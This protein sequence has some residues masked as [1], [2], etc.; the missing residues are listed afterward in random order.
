MAERSNQFVLNRIR[1]MINWTMLDGQLYWDFT[2]Y[3]PIYVSNRVTEGTRSTTDFESIFKRKP[4]LNKLHMF[5]AFTV[6]LTEVKNKVEPKGSEGY[7]M[8]Y[9][10]LTGEGL[11]VDKKKMNL[12]KTRNFKISKRT[13]ALEGQ[14]KNEQERNKVNIIPYCPEPELNEVSEDKNNTTEE[15][16]QNELETMNS[17][18]S[19]TLLPE[20]AFLRRSRRQ[21]KTPDR[22]TYADVVANDTK[23]PFEDVTFLFQQP[24]LVEYASVLVVKENS[25]PKSYFQIKNKPEAENGTRHI[26]KNWT[27]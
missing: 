13:Q 12:V 2:T 23:F 1:L 26:T 11:I 3:Y 14:D 18:E 22:L 9:N 24:N 4:K 19:E 21:V 8:G 10:Y 5:G 27:N 6:Y 25:M 17:T 15:E 7:F 20:E 16:K